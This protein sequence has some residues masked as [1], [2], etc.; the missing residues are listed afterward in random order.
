M[1]TFGVIFNAILERPPSRQCGLN[2]DLPHKLEDIIGKCLEK[3]RNLRYQHAADIRADLQRLKRDTE[4]GKVQRVTANA[5]VVAAGDGDRAVALVF[6]IAIIGGSVL[7]WRPSSDGHQLGRRTAVLQCERRPQFGIHQRRDYR[8][9]H[10]PV[11]GTAQPEGHL[12]H[13]R[14]SLQAP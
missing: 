13:I 14:V 5:S 10:R 11:V 7:F 6:I 4:S 12:A 9:R 1:A 3:D 2:P 8:R